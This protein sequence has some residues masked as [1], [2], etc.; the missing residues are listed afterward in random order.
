MYFQSINTLLTEVSLIIKTAED[1]KQKSGENFNIFRILG[2]STYEVRTHTA[3]IS[4]LLNPK[5]CHGHND[6]FLNLF[7]KQLARVKQK[8]DY[9]N[10][11]GAE[12]KDSYISRISEDYTNGG[13]LDIYIANNS[14]QAIIIE[15]KIYHHD[16]KAQLKRYHN[17]GKKHH[18]TGFDLI[19]LTLDG[20]DPSPESKEDLTDKEY[21]KLSYKEHILKW[22][23][24]CKEEVQVS[25][26]VTL[27]ETIMQYI[28][29]VKLLTNQSINDNMNET[30]ADLLTKPLLIESAFAVSNNIGLTMDKL[31]NKF[32]EDIKNFNDWGLVYGQDKDKTI[33][34]PDFR[35]FYYLN[36]W[37]YCAIGFCFEEKNLKEFFYGICRK[38]MAIEIPPDTFFKIQKQL[39]TLDV[40]E[41]P[42][43]YWPWCKFHDQINW[44]NETYIKIAKGELQESIKSEILKLFV[45][46]K[47]IDM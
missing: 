27:R 31:R 34:D 12:M 22:L 1:K 11:S 25:E 20:R 42:N 23:E 9:F 32:F 47:D 43:E 6:L 39:N 33:F 29:L 41:R 30:I 18:A 3:F 28:N 14:N 13:N 46:I 17:F 15:N 4:E 40:P 37:K 44:N 8:E 10:C 35:F 19:Y 16:E 21:I 45:N 7:V 2:L 38:D 26:H 5:G 24:L 36:S